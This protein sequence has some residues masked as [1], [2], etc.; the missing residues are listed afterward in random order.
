VPSVERAWQTVEH[1][2]VVLEAKRGRTAGAET[3]ASRL[4]GRLN[5][6]EIDGLMRIIEGDHE[7][8][9]QVAADVAVELRV[10]ERATLAS[11]RPATTLWT[12]IPFNVTEGRRAT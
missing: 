11:D 12:S 4:P 9:Q 8:L 5:T 3:I 6:L 7:A 10:A 2:H 1:R